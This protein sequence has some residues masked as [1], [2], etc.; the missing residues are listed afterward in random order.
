M[1]FRF[2]GSRCFRKLLAS[3]PHWRFSSLGVCWDSVAH[4]S[5]AELLR[6]QAVNLRNLV[7]QGNG[8]YWA[9]GR[10]NRAGFRF[11][12]HF[13]GLGCGGRYAKGVAK[14]EGGLMLRL[15]GD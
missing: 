8:L 2:W 4:I 1:K 12:G 14:D 11:R 5:G 7:R 10:A 3:A 9:E 6:R 15:R 13:E